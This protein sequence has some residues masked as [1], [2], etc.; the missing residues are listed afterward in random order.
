VS[1]S[2][3]RTERID[4]LDRTGTA[5]THL[6]SDRV[7]PHPTSGVEPRVS[8]SPGRLLVLNKTPHIDWLKAEVRP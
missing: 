2:G 3:V 7:R 4:F 6:P 5:D 8:R 1:S